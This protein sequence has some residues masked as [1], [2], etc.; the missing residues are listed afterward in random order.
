MVDLTKLSDNDLLALS[1]KDLGSVSDEGLQAI[2]QP[3]FPVA[4]TREEQLTSAGLNPADYPEAT[5]SAPSTEDIIAGSVGEALGST[6]RGTNLQQPAKQFGSDLVRE[7]LKTVGQ[8]VGGVVAATTPYGKAY[9]VMASWLGS[10]VGGATGSE[11]E[12]YLGLSDRTRSLLGNITV[13]AA[14]SALG[15]WGA[16][17]MNKYFFRKLSK[18]G[19]GIGEKLVSEELVPVV[20]A[21]GTTVQEA[22]KRQGVEG[23]TP[24]EAFENV[25]TQRGALDKLITKENIDLTKKNFGQLS[26]RNATIK[27]QLDNKLKLPADSVPMEDVQRSLKEITS[28]KIKALDTNIKQKEIALSKLATTSKMG[29]VNVDK[30]LLANLKDNA[31]LYKK[32]LGTETYN[33]VVDDIDRVIGGRD[34]ITFGEFDDL[35]LKLSSRVKDDPEMAVVAFSIADNAAPDGFLTVMRNGMERFETPEAKAFVEVFD[36]IGTIASLKSNPVIRGLERDTANSIEKALKSKEAYNSFTT[37]L[38]GEL[39]EETQDDLIRNVLF[40]KL[41]KGTKGKGELYDIAGFQNVMSKYD[42]DVLKKVMGEEGYQDLLDA[43]AINLGMSSQALLSLAKAT[44][45][46]A[47]T[48]RAIFDAAARVTGVAPL[49]S[50]K[51]GV[52]LVGAKVRNFLGLDNKLLQ[53]MS[54]GRAYKKYTEMAGLEIGDPKF[55]AEYSALMKILGTNPI[56]PELFERNLENTVAELPAQ[57]E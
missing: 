15:E 45:V 34:Y 6:F 27:A 39:T 42:P 28:N 37:V 51:S 33:K 36:D 48:K 54:S 31:R 13:N 52:G 57:S 22:V 12:R 40:S 43:Q 47:E 18:D 5:I 55:Y 4:P 53:R 1:N 21:T 8:T 7:P 17:A 19:A 35:F 3:A 44:D 2:S 50:I 20:G 38:G 26:R 49:S 11:T 10:T 46:D 25:Y 41:A 30:P 56:S 16:K 14:E 23:I 24:S 32:A 29:L 9:P